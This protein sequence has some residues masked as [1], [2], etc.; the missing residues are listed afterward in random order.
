MPAISLPVEKQTKVEIWKKADAYGMKGLKVDGNDLFTMY[1]TAKKEVERV[2]KEQK[3]VLIEAVSYRIGP[4]STS[5]DPNKYRTAE[6]TDGSEKDPL[7][8]AEK[9]MIEHNYLTAEE[10]EK[11]KSDAKDNIEKIF[12]EREK[13]PAP[14]PD[15]MFTDV[16]EKNNW[17]ID[18][19]KEE[20]L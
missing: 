3:P 14:S 8:I 18:E 15:T 20:I 1:E 17:I 4:H 2:R 16:Y 7:T 6:I 12:D 11:I 13:L 5:D 10:I 19:E 9:K